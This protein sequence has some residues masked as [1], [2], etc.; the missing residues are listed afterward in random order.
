MSLT[1]LQLY[2]RISEEECIVQHLFLSGNFQKLL[3]FSTDS[4]FSNSRIARDIVT[5]HYD[6]QDHNHYN[7][8]LFENVSL[9]VNNRVYN[10]WQPFIYVYQ[11][12]S[13]LHANGALMFCT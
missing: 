8:G 3:K 13:Q 6:Q 11:D 12:Q 1:H 4:F 10:L 9:N 2:H 7:D 5:T